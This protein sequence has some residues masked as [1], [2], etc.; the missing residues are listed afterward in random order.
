[1]DKEVANI[2]IY[3]L[4]MHQTKRDVHS[5]WMLVAKTNYF[6]SLDFAMVF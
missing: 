4:E 2:C 5:K 3:V 6:I 1:M